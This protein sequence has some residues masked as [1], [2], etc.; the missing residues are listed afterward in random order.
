MENNT[1]Q[2]KQLEF[3]PY[4]RENPTKRE[5]LANYSASTNYKRENSSNSLCGAASVARK[6]SY[7]VTEP[8]RSASKFDQLRRNLFNRKKS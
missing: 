5:P 6:R 7:E 4:L 2:S 1:V 3:P 8:A